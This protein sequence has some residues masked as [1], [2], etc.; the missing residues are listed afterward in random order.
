MKS[1]SLKQGLS[2]ILA[3]LVCLGTPLNAADPVAIR[4][5]DVSLRGGVLTGM[6]LNTEAKPVAGLPVHLLHGEKLVATVHS[7]ENGQFA[8]KGLRTG[9]HVLQVGTNQHPV[10]FWTSQSA[11]PSATSRMAIVVDEVIV[12]GQSCGDDGCE[13]PGV[14]GMIA[15]NPGPLLLIGGAAAATI[16]ITAHNSK[17]DQPAPASP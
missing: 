9:G 2:L 4:S 3:G 15:A 8:V 16:A 5:S 10:R 12:R 6:V 13:K 14:L 7:D 17:D 1:L 11:P